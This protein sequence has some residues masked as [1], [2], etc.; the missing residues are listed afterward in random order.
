MVGQLVLGCL[1]SQ[2]VDYLRCILQELLDF[3]G[4][5]KPFL[6]GACVKGCGFQC[7]SCNI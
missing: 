2:R 5:D 1:K 4:V 6:K 7:R 3:L